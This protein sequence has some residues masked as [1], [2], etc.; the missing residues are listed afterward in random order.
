MA[1]REDEWISGPVI[2]NWV[3]V[4]PVLLG[5]IFTFTVIG[6][7]NFLQ[8]DGLNDIASFAIKFNYVVLDSV[9]GICKIIGG[10]DEITVL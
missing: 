3:I 10:D 5:P 7:E 9:I 2:I 1:T 4:E 6:F 8:I